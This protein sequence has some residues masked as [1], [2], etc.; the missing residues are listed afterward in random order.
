[1]EIKFKKL[2]ENGI[3]PKRASLSEAGYDAY[4]TETIWIKPGQRV[5]IKT[6]IAMSI[7]EGFFGRICDRSSLALKHGIHV[8]G[9]ILDSNFRGNIGIIL[10][11]LSD[12]GEEH[13]YQV[14]K[15]DR[16]AQIIFEEYIPVYFT[17][18]N[19][20]DTTDRGAGGFG[21]TGV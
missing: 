13:S 12:G 9:G 1:M 14:K 2:S 3:V 7:P 18:V 15:G 19:E 6:D 11:N 16:I 17:E 8:L 5:L 21:S 20:L 4:S 10:I